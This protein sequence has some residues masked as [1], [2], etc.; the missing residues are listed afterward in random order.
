MKVLQEIV[1]GSGNSR[2]I[3][4]LGLAIFAHSSLPIFYRLLEGEIGPFST[5]FHRVWLATLLLGLWNG[6]QYLK[7]QFS[8]DKSVKQNPYTRLVILQ[9]LVAGISFAGNQL[10]LAWSLSQ[11]TVANTT[12]LTNMTPIW[13]VLLGWL[14]WNQTFDKVFLIGMAVA[15]VGACMI[16]LQDW[17]LATGNLQGDGVAIMAALFNSTYLLP[18]ESLRSQ[19]SSIAILSWTCVIS[20][21]FILP[22]ALMTETQVF[23]HT[24]SGWLFVILLGLICQL[25]AVGLVT[26]CLK[27]I[28]SGLIAVSKLLIPI[29]N[30]FL[31]WLFFSEILSFWNYVAFTVVILGL[32]ISKYS[33]IS[34]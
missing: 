23:P 9:L 8:P 2:A 3:G 33:K 15:V 7:N 13:T 6:A 27:K 34:E 21:L 12:I 10:L 11:M 16:G 1:S 31:A 24:W 22:I 29:I 30:A 5:A 14:I 26:Y 18:V 4:F 17:Q 19:L 25:L 20:T 32:Y 28:S